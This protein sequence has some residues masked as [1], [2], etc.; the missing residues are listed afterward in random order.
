MNLI[1]NRVLKWYAKHGRHDLPWQNTKD[2]YRIWVSE[3]ML[4]QTQV[5]TVI[6]YYRR[7]MERFP[8]IAELAQAPT[9]DVLHLWTG[10][11]YYA[12][13]RNLHKSA[14]IIHKQYNNRFPTCFDEVIGLPGIGR[15]TAGAILAFSSQQHFAILDGN[16]KRVLARFYE[17]E[18]WYGV[19]AVENKLWKLAEANTPKDGVDK[20]TQAIMDLGATLCTR[21]KPNCSACPL[22]DD[23]LAHKNDRTGELPHGKPKKTK[24][25]KSTYML[26]VKNQQDEFLLQQNPPS[27]IWGGLWCP[28]QLQSLEQQTN[29]QVIKEL[30]VMRH[31]FSHY[32]LDITPVLCRPHGPSHENAEFVA[33]SSTLLPSLWYKSGSE[34]AL[35]LAAPVKKLLEQYA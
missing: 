8:T 34:T 16:V 22:Q 6:P 32:H 29:Y 12:R 19:K 3:I 5:T 26:L 31:T 14:Q 30:P 20:Y 2:A 17:I 27:G 13:A 9:D 35:G 21:S 11:G 33:E 7:F 23:C 1:S 25:V 15:S 10:L 4:Q 18:G 28:P 24:P